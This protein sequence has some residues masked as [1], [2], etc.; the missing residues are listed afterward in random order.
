VTSLAQTTTAMGTVVTIQIVG[1]D[2]SPAEERERAEYVRRA[3]EWFTRVE[4]RCSRFDPTSELRRLCDGVG[5]VVEVSDI[6]F[7]TTRFALALAKETGGAFDPTL[8]AYDSVILDADARTLTL[9][10]PVTIDLGAVAKGF[11]VD[12][13]A[14]EL[15]PL[16]NFAIDAG[17][18][19]YLAGTN[20]D[21]APWSVGIRHP[22]T[23][24]ELLTTIAVTDTAVCT[25]GDYER[26]QHIL[27]ARRNAPA[28]GIAS[29]TTIAPLAMVADA[30]GTAAFVLGVER[31]IE[32]LER[33]GVEGLIVTTEL[34][35]FRTR[36]GRYLT[37]A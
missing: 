20:M 7:E 23:E 36:G 35:E 10:R 26:G 5:Q 27:D 37:A 11:A 19:L 12:M 32:L 1:H 25:S 22:R 9:E 18:D 34:E 6:L 33:H 13:A 17:G 8:G 29:V 4:Q 28:Q 30:L 31:G 16:G 14:R 21:G 24:G 15:A 2:A 3:F